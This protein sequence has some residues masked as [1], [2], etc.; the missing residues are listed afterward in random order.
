MG[1]N[2][3]ICA[4]RCTYL[5]SR[6]QFLFHA[7]QQSRMSPDPRPLG[8]GSDVQ[9]WKVRLFTFNFISQSEI[10]TFR[11]PCKLFPRLSVPWYINC[12]NDVVWETMVI[13][14]RFDQAPTLMVWKA[15]MGKWDRKGMASENCI[16]VN[17]Q[18]R[19]RNSSIQRRSKRWR[20]W[21]CSIHCDR[22]AFPRR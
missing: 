12:V 15:L 19:Q 13:T 4:L 20:N 2:N 3:F 6:S 1:G 5:I 8:N 17:L 16:S 22:L 9:L 7:L 14:S 11:H 21:T 10:P 18:N